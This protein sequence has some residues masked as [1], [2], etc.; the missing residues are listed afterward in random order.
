MSGWDDAR[1]VLAVRLDTLGDVLMTTPA[2]HALL[3]AGPGGREIT[4]LTSTFGARITPLLPDVGQV[5]IHDPPWMKHGSHPAGPD[6]DLA[7]I[8]R[9]RDGA[10]DAAV[11]FTVYSQSPLPAALLCH[12]AGIPLRLAHCRENPYRLLTD[13]VLE[14]EPERHVRHEVR[15]QLDLVAAAGVPAPDSPLRLALPASARERA[16][17]LLDEAGVDRSRPWIVVHPGATAPSRRY[18]PWRYAEA[19]RRMVVA[20]GTQVVVTGSADEVEVAT[21]LAAAVR[22]GVVVLAGRTPLDVLAGVLAESSLLVSN[23]TGPVHMAAALGTPVVVL[24]ALTNPQHMPWMVPSRVLSH[25]VPC[26][27]CYK[28]VCPMGHHL[29]LRA[30]RP[31]EVVDAIRQM[32]READAPA[33]VQPSGGGVV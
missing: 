30:V 18:P 11:I 3:E 19:L 31:E 14:T 6:A 29:C 16:R 24:Y 21:D 5:V 9:L 27:W 2:L 26:R 15:R 20:D 22:D 33:S 12:L 10:F 8:E 25:D 13:W 7:L 4:L 28:S 17:A 23:N 1:R 32:L